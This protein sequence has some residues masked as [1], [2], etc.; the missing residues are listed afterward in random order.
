MPTIALFEA[1]NRLSELVDRVQAGERFDITRRGKVVARL[2]G[3]VVDASV[4]AAWFLPDE[5]TPCTEAAL[6]A[7]A[8][9]AVWVPSLWL[10]G[11]GN[12][13][14]SAQR[15]KRIDERKRI[16]LAADVTALGVHVDRTPV[17]ISHLDALAARHGL[18]TC[19]A[20]YLELALRRKLPLA[21]LDKALQAAMHAEKVPVAEFPA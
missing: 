5:A 16:A 17:S 12:L 19:D 20:V 3:V 11:I 4:A 1:K 7:T 6:L 13:L 15:R 8:T 14:P 10:L 18:T 2:A 21:T 9:D